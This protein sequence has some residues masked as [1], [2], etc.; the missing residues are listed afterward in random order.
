MFFIRILVMSVLTVFLFMP[1]TINAELHSDTVLGNGEVYVDIQRNI[2]RGGALYPIF[3]TSKN[4]LYGYP[5]HVICTLREVPYKKFLVRLKHR[6]DFKDITVYD[7]L[8]VVIYENWFPYDV[9]TT[10]REVKDFEIHE[11]C[12]ISMVTNDERMKFPLVVEIP[13]ETTPIGNKLFWFTKW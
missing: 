12:E 3:Y 6:Y 4:D 11:Y 7:D 5:I 9:K 1:T 8:R 2:T 10:Y 13:D